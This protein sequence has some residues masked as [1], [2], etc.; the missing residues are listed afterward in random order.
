MHFIIKFIFLCAHSSH[1][2]NCQWTFDTDPHLWL[3]LWTWQ[4]SAMQQAEYKGEIA[5]VTNFMTDMVS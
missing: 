1:K 2:Y 4:L 5:A 3:E